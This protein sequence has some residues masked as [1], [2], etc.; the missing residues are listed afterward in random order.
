MSARIVIGDPPN[1]GK[2]TLAESLARALRS[3]GVDACAE[4]LDLA[5]PTLAFIRGEMGW[6][7]RPGDKREWKTELARRAELFLRRHPP[8]I[9]S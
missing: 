1:S 7:E 8:F 6:E 9:E 4:D 2:S 5:S 3:L